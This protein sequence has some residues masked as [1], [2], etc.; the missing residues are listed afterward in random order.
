[1]TVPLSTHKTRRLL[2]LYFTGYPQPVIAKRLGVSQGTVSNYAAIFAGR[3][4]EIGL[5]NAGKEFDI[6]NEVD[7]LRSLSV[8]LYKSEITLVEAKQ[9]HNIIMAFQKLGVG[10][11]QHLALVKVCQKV[12]DPDFVKAALKLSQ[13]ESQTGRSYQQAISGFEQAQNQLPQLEERIA[14]AKA[15][16]K[17]TSDALTKAQQKLASQKEYLMKYQNEVKAK[18]AQLEKELSAKM[19]QLGVEKKEVEEVAVLKA[20]LT[21][22]G[23]TLPTLLKLAKEFGHGNK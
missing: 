20:E 6:M 23:L 22:R 7:S 14:D 4:E 2:K 13:I 8:E 1:M 3:A 5:L 19:K 17:A 12:G 9:G 10:P 18:E 15:E 16:L 21:K 11:E